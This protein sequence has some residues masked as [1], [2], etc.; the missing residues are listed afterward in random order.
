MSLIY[1]KYSLKPVRG[2][3]ILGLVFAVLLCI[4][5][6]LPF[7]VNGQAVS[8]SMGNVLAILAFQFIIPGLVN[9]QVELVSRESKQ[10]YLLTGKKWTSSLH[11][12]LLEVVDVCLQALI[13]LGL[14]CLFFAIFH[15]QVLLTWEVVLFYILGSLVYFEIS[16]SLTLFLKS[17]LSALALLLLFP[18][19]V[20]PY[21]ERVVPFLASTVFYQSISDSIQ[22]QAE[23]VQ[24][25]SVLGWGM[26]F[27]G[28]GVWKLPQNYKK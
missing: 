18:L 10:Y 7:Q 5:T 2:Q 11:L 24:K 14:V 20:S 6:L 16:Y 23:L 3:L 27:F 17:S 28:L 25:I 21:L 12:F 4:L 15:H 9:G 8:L 13:A 1:K 22:G 26:L 19:L